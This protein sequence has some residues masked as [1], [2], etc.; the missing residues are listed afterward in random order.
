MSRTVRSSLLGAVCCALFPVVLSGQHI[1]AR[2]TGVLGSVIEFNSPIL[3]NS[4]PVSALNG[5]T[6]GNAYSG[7]AFFSGSPFATG[8]I[9]NVPPAL[10]NIAFGAISIEFPMALM[11]AAF[12]LATDVGAT[13]FSAYLNGSL[14][15]TFNSATDFSKSSSFY[16]FEGFEFDRIEVRT[17][18]EGTTGQIAF[19]G[20]DN[21]QFASVPAAAVL[22]PEP[23]TAAMIFGGVIALFAYRRRRSRYKT[24]TAAHG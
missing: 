6:F 22:A 20:I 13:T 10:S 2:A 18:L 7:S 5:V 24:S 14:V 4:T 19:T 11:G 1:D 3:P 23:S 12:N 16:G 9:Y 21:L 8:A 17:V 15:E